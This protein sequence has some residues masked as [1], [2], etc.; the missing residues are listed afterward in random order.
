MTSLISLSRCAAIAALVSFT[1]LP[2]LANS[3][4]G[5]FAPGG[6]GPDGLQPGDVGPHP[7]VNLTP[8]TPVGAS[9]GGG[10]A[11][12]T[13]ADHCLRGEMMV[14]FELNEDNNV[15]P[16]TLQRDCVIMR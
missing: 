11:I 14:S 2:A 16:S 10:G 7:G 1:A 12:G 4:S 9:D 5:N 6:N 3:A 15:I 8:S 13:A